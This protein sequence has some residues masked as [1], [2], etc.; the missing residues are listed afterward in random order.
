MVFSCFELRSEDKK[1]LNITILNDPLITPHIYSR[2][3]CAYGKFPNNDEV[4]QYFVKMLI[5]KFWFNMDPDY[6]DTGS[7]FYGDG[8][9]HTYE[10]PD[11]R[12]D[13]HYRRP[14]PRLV[15]P[16]PRAIALP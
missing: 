7:N 15:Q 2:F 16:H 9:G 14:I 11:A 13:V 1:W 3:L 5:A 4:P 10:Q 8:K 6:I 12:R